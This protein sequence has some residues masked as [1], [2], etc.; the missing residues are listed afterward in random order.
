MVLLMGPE[1]VVVKGGF[2][3]LHV[4]AS[5]GF[6]A[7]CPGIGARPMRDSLLQNAARCRCVPSMRDGKENR[8]LFS[9]SS[10]DSVLDEPR[11]CMLLLFFLLFSPF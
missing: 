8:E 9:C 11:H 1:N 2:R 4:G 5:A 7:G 10:L 6:Y 3:W